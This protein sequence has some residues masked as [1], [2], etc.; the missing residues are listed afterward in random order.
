MQKV[1]LRD[2]AT[3]PEAFKDAIREQ[4]LDEELLNGDCELSNV[5]ARMEV[6]RSKSARVTR[7]FGSGFG[8][9]FEPTGNWYFEF[10]ILHR[11]N[12][13]SCLFAT[14]LVSFEEA[15]DIVRRIEN[16]GTS[17]QDS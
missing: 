9:G 8:L 4:G 5:N 13:Y 2:H 17:R 10:E 3:W 6:S 1:T 7:T 12:C 15:K 16:A 11:E 14:D